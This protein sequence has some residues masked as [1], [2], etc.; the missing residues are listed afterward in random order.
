MGSPV[1]RLRTT[2]SAMTQLDNLGALD[3]FVRA[4]DTRSFTRAGKRLGISSSAVGKAIAR[5]EEQ[6]DVRLFHRT[7]RSVALTTEGTMLLARCRKIFGEVEAAEL[8]LAKLRGAPRGR[9]RVSF[10]LVSRAYVGVISDFLRAY[11]G[12]EL[13]LD[14][15]DRTVDVVEEGFD[16][17]VRG[18]GKLDSRLASRVIGKTHLRLAAS[19][20][21][22]ALRGVPR[23]VP[24]LREHSCLRYRYHDTGKLDPWDLGE[25]IVAPETHVA[26]TADSLLGLAEQGLGIVYLPDY[27]LTQPIGRGALVPILEDVPRRTTTLRILWPSSRHMSPALRAFIDFMAVRLFVPAGSLRK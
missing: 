7:T 8:E 26:N 10:P 25:G 13:D 15:S 19:P 14:F 2:T 5:L 17:V 12:I 3:V 4:A 23:T 16:A 11:P 9:L 27:M 1:R 22:L 18:G 21:Y 20:D 6:L 24:E